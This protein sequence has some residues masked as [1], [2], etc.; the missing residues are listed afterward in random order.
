ML[1]LTLVYAAQ[2]VQLQADNNDEA[3]MHEK[4][5]INRVDNDDDDV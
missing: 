4:E 2:S 3:E 5:P 1:V